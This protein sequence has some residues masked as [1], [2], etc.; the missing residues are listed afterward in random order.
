[1]CNCGKKRSSLNISVRSV[2]S[3]PAQVKSQQGVVVRS[4]TALTTANQTILFQ[5]IGNTA[6]SIIGRVT[7]KSYRFSFPGDVKPVSVVDAPD[8]KAVPVLK[9]VE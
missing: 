9:M 6:L 4:E 5:Y 1:M 8:M 7:R 3:P 2:A